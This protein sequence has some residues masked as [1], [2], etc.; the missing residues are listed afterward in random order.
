MP[1]PVAER[2][3]VMS[4]EIQRIEAK[5]VLQNRSERSPLA[6]ESQAIQDAI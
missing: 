4:R 1:E 6:P 2:I 3:A 5:R